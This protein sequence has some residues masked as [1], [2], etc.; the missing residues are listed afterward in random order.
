MQEDKSVLLPGQRWRVRL[1]LTPWLP[2]LYLFQ[3][4]VLF[5]H[6]SLLFQSLEEGEVVTQRRRVCLGL[7]DSIRPPSLVQAFQEGQGGGRP[8]FVRQ[9]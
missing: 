2:A 6:V 5:V 9:E 3:I 4:L 7:S 1:L 8:L